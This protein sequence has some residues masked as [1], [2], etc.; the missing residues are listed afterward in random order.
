M[1]KFHFSTFQNICCLSVLKDF[2]G[3]KQY[4]IQSLY[5]LNNDD[6]LKQSTDDNSLPTLPAPIDGGKNEDTTKVTSDNNEHGSSDDNQVTITDTLIESSGDKSAGDK[7]VVTTEDV[8][9]VKE[10]KEFIMER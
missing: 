6:Q 7:P 3:L 2:V 4:N 1:Q 8:K 9:G 10:D 5:T